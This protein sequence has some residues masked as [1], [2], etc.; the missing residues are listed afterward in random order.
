MPK[1][2]PWQRAVFRF[3][4][5]PELRQDPELRRDAQRVV[6]AHLSLSMW[7]PF[8]GVV[9]AMLGAPR[10]AEIIFLTGGLNIC[11]LLLLRATKSP[12]LC[13]NSL[14]VVILLSIVALAVLSGGIYSPVIPWLAYAPAFALVL[15]GTAAGVFWTLVCALAVT[16]LTAAPHFGIPL[17]NELS[18]F[19]TE[20]GLYTGDLALLV[21][22]LGTAW[23]FKQAEED[24][25]QALHEENEWL[26]AEASTDPVTQIPNRR[27]FDRAFRQEWK[28][29]AR[30][31]LP[32]T[33]V[34]LD[35]DNFKQ[36]NDAVGHAGGDDCL[37]IVA[38]AVDQMLHRPGDFVARFGGEEFAV[39]LPD[40]PEP[41][42][43]IMAER[44]RCCIKSLAIAHPGSSLGH[45]TV[46]A[47]CGTIV[48][49]EGD[50]LMEFM[51]QVDLALYRAK[52][53]GRDQ[54]VPVEP[55]V[56][57]IA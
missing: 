54:C 49:G 45:V 50:S 7:S 8:Y 56:V 10:C 48:P 33:L 2:A 25:R 13:G 14:C 16:A 52:A 5:P 18:P 9:T 39:V 28:R 26:A 43:L 40:T 23:L 51:H 37:R 46:S 6:V 3:F 30:G 31:G 12:A 47:G 22:V 4:I 41:E 32:L 20:F 29:H 44:I 1:S 36:F 17:Y 11:S 55:E 34:A 57:E 53:A 19:A 38:T 24:V 27:F 15:S 35:I 42:G 21:V